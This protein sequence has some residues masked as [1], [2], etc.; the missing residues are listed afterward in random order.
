MYIPFL[1]RF[2]HKYVVL[3]RPRRFGKSL[4]VSMLSCYYDIKMRDRFDELFSGLWIHENPTEERGSYMILRLS[5]AGIDVS[6][7]MEAIYE[8]FLSEV[9]E[10]ARGLVDTY[11]GLLGKTDARSRIDEAR[12]PGSV[13]RVLCTEAMRSGIKLYVLIDEYDNFINELV[14][15]Q[16]GGDYYDL[17]TAGGMVKAFYKALKEGANSGAISRIFITGVSPLVLEDLTSGFNIAMNLSLRPELNSMLGFKEEEVEDLVRRAV[18]DGM[19]P[20]EVMGLMRE[21]YDGYLFSRRAKERIYNPDM[22]LHF[23]SELQ[24]TGEYPEEML[25]TNVR[26]DYERI[27][28]IIEMVGEDRRKA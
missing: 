18:P 5:F 12:S 17:L 16:K 25:H 10:K 13:L 1:E 19:D 15:R 28:R 24:T 27:R 2:E 21:Y 7:G 22:V 6:S 20:D 11:A 14:A 8:G 9:K 3:L 4:M 23:L 26:T